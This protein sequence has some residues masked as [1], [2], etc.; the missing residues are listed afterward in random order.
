M[1]ITIKTTIDAQIAGVESKSDVVA[2]LVLEEQH[3]YYAI[4][5]LLERYNK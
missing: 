5:P 3:Y 2:Y 1:N 4:R